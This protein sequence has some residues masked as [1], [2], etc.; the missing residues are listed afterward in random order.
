[1]RPNGGFATTRYGLRGQRHVA[2]VGLE[3]G[4]V[5]ACRRTAA[6]AGPASVGS[7]START[8]R[9]RAASAAVEHT[10]AGAEIDDAVVAADAGVGDEPGGE[11][12]ATEEVL[13]ERRRPSVARP[14]TEHRVHDETSERQPST[15]RAASPAHFL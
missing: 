9:A 11:L 3:H 13:P 7:S 15:T 5:R 10:G 14:G 2:E 1:M 6:R 4:D 8:D 12:L